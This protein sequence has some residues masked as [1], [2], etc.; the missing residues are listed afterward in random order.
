MASVDYKKCKAGT[1]AAGALLRHCDARE[2]L[3]HEHTNEHIDKDLMPFN[4]Q[5]DKSYRQTMSALRERLAELDAV[6]G[7]N[8]R[9]DRVECFMLEVPIP[10]GHDPQRFAK[11]AVREISDMYGDRNVLNWYLHVDEVHDYMD[12]GEVRRSL[13]HIH[14]PVVPE[15]NG[16]LNGKAFSSRANMVELNKRIDAGA[17]EL[18]GPAF[19]TGEHPRKRSVEELKISSYR[20]ASEAKDRAERDRD[21]AIYDAEAAERRAERA[22][23]DA[24]EARRRAQEAQEAAE[25]GRA[26]VNAMRGQIEAL[27]AVLERLNAEGGLSARKVYKAFGGE[28]YIRVSPAEARALDAAAAVKAPLLEAEAQARQLA[29][30]AQDRVDALVRQAGIE[31]EFYRRKAQEMAQQTK[32]SIYEAVRMR[33]SQNR[34]VDREFPGD[35]E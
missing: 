20:E 23:R 15:M 3:R 25:T 13:A 16:K 14:V 9:K 11:M 26:Y 12:H 1:G 32:R 10:A 33:P 6:Q 21:Y 34:S 28:E 30:D 22:D 4:A 2:R 24:Q 29:A 19:L 35:R 5:G 31:I 27:E 8:R 17:R 18:G 7:A